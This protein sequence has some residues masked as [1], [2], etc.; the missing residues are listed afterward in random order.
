VV[1]G[2]TTRSG[3]ALSAAFRAGYASAGTLPSE[4]QLRW[5]TA[6]ALLTERAVRAIHRIRWVGLQRISAL[7]REARSLLDG[8]DV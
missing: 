5:H 3:S 8:D 4:K 2:L 6:A 1:G 7:L